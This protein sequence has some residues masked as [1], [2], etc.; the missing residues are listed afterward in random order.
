MIE[1]IIEI[2]GAVC[3]ARNLT[4]NASESKRAVRGG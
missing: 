2:A 1:T 4:A 3:M